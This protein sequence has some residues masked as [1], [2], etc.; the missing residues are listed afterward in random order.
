MN[1]KREIIIAVSVVLVILIALL[2]GYKLGSKS[3]KEM[4]NSEVKTET[5]VTT[6]NQ[7]NNDANQSTT[8]SLDKDS[9]MISLDDTWNLY[10]NYKLGFSIKIPKYSLAS[11]SGQ[12][13]GKNFKACPG[14]LV[15]IIAI[16]DDSNAK[17]YIVPSKI[18][19]QNVKECK[20]VDLALAKKLVLANNVDSEQW[21]ITIKNIANENQLT[22]AVRNYWNDN[23][24]IASNKKATQYA[25]TFDVSVGPIKDTGAG[26]EDGC[27]LNWMIGAKYSPESQKLAL[28]NVGQEGV[29]WLNNNSKED[30]TYDDAMEE[31]FQFIK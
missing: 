10:K 1:K 27:F 2:A 4:K 21:A 28:W 14:K 17:V 13:Y 6:S 22:G 26:P 5:Q 12:M 30:T 15:S 3:K 16:A 25:G 9:E 7:T 19:D 31:S 23:K 11:D 18:Y 20:N 8:S 29:F 24:C